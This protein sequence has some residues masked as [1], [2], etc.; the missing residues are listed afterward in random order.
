MADL[1]RRFG[2]LDDKT[3]ESLGDLQEPKVTNF[4]GEVVGHIK[5]SAKPPI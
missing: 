2:V 4:A 3:M 5:L 1:L